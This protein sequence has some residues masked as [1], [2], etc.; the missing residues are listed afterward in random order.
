MVGNAILSLVWSTGYN[1]PCTTLE[2]F[3]L[4]LFLP[5]SHQSCVT[6]YPKT[7]SIRCSSRYADCPLNS[8]KNL[9]GMKIEISFPRMSVSP[10]H[11]FLS[12]LS[13]SIMLARPRSHHY[14]TLAASHSPFLFFFPHSLPSLCHSRLVRLVSFSCFILA[15]TDRLAAIVNPIMLHLYREAIMS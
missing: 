15:R 12:S 3:V 10:F 8:E 13:S 5:S 14:R 1:Q 4:S 9:P 11:P 2:V 7:K 6:A